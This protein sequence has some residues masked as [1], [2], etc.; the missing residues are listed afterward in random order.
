[1]L[2][3]YKLDSKEIKKRLN[4]VLNLLEI[5]RSL[6]KKYPSELSSGQGQKI[7]FALALSV[8]AKYYLLDEPSAFL[9]KDTM[10]LFKKAILY[11]Q[12]T[13]KSGFLIASHDKIS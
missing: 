8:R 11:M 3:T 1:M 4:E 13:Y 6:L 2:K 9:D 10:I 7:A 5:D 12:K